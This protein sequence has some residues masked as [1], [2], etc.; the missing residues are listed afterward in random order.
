MVQVSAKV[1]D[2]ELKF[3]VDTGASVSLIPY[4]ANKFVH[5]EPSVVKLST[6]NN[7]PIKGDRLGR[8]N[9]SDILTYWHTEKCQIGI[10]ED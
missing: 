9:V 8:L 4:E 10:L 5:I 6:A 1:E 7:L 2:S 3:I